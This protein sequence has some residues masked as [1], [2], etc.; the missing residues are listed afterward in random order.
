MKRIL[1]P[2]VMDDADE[3]TSYDALV[4]DRQ[5]R[6]LDECFARSALNLGIS[7]GKILDIGTGTGRIPINIAK[8]CPK[9]KIV[10][11]DLSESMLA[12]AKENSEDEKVSDK[13]KFEF[14]DAKSL[15]FPDNHF[16]LV[17]SHVA[18]HHIPD[19]VSVLSEA[20][21]VLRGGGDVN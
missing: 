1:E 11:V 7:E 19:P 8:L 18:M 14:A 21:R 17:I 15:P 12:V 16:D 20:N 2:E 4:S 5:G 3:A 9:F 13:I 6:I 10:A